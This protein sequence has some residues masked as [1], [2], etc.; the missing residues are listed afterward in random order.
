MKN[1]HL[2]PK[3]E[4]KQKVICT[5]DVCQGECGSCNFMTL[6]NVEEPKQYKCTECNWVGVF[7]E[8]KNEQDI[9]YDQYCCPKCN[10]VIYDCRIGK[11]YLEEE[12]KQ[13]TLEEIAERMYQNKAAQ[14]I[15]ISGAKWKQERMYSEAN[16][17]MIFLDNEYKLGISDKQ[18]I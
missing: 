13:E 2:I 7:N 5:N 9:D 4:P 14:G 10:N 15:F 11:W 8:M 18:T 6:V 16:K 1:L 12:P 3:Q 17:I